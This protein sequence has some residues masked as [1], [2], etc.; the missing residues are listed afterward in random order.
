FKRHATSLTLD[1]SDISEWQPGDIVV[2][3]GHIG[4]VS[5]TRNYKGITFIIH[6]GSVNQKS[7]IQDIL[8][9]NKHNIIGHYR[10]S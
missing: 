8:E 7:Y 2:F 5:D 10:I 4:I 9:K 3:N 1:P 6:H